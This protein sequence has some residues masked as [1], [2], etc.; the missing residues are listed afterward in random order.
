MFFFVLITILI[1]GVLNWLSWKISKYSQDS[2]CGGVC[3][4]N[5]ASRDI[6]GTKLK[7]CDGA[8]VPQKCATIDLWKGKY[9]SS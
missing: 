2:T 5:A 3:F 6:S 7:I 9:T 4:Y 1:K 8:F